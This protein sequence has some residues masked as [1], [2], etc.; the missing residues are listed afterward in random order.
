VA[1]I[2][3]RIRVISIVGRFLEHSR[4]FYFENNG[5]PEIYLSSADLMSR[6]LDRRVELMFPVEEPV[7][8]RRL[9]EEVLDVALADS[10]R[11]RTL[12]ANGSYMHM[13]TNGDTASAD[14]QSIIMRSRLRPSRPP[15]LIPRDTP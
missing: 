7:L 15:H 13:P 12:Q 6:N 1:H 14:S 10:V 11:A 8:A 3:E 9:K 2:S 4:V 5:A